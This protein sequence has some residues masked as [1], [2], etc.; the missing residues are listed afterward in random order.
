MT[1][2]I[3]REPRGLFPEIFDWLE[4]P[5]A[6]LRP[7]IGPAIRFEDHVKDGRY[8]LLAELP[9]IDPD[10]DLEITLTDGVLA[11]HAE[12]HHEEKDTHRTEF[13]YGAL[14]R[15]IVLPAGADPKDVRA[16]YDK[17]LL[18]ISVKLDDSKGAGV[19]IPVGKARTTR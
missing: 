10:K 6:G 7:A 11:I 19:R 1:T 9:G 16:V 13:R 17:G 15:S 12:R 5:L 2:L 3:R 4:A 14:T 8:V 18:E